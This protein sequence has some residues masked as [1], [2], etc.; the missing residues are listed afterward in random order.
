ML[1]ILGDENG[2]N[3]GHLPIVRSG[4]DAQEN[5]VGETRDGRESD[6]SGDKGEDFPGAER[7]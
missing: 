5:G 2:L 6:E 1:A 7:L 4:V 3:A